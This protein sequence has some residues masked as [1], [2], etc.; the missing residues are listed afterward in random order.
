MGTSAR[1]TER[2]GE[3]GGLHPQVRVPGRLHLGTFH[4]VLGAQCLLA[5][6]HPPSFPPPP[7]LPAPP[8][9]GSLSVHPSA[10][11]PSALLICQL[12]LS[13]SVCPSPV[14][15]PLLVSQSVPVTLGPP[16]RRH[17]H[18]EQRRHV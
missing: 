7:S 15:I 8:Q 11:Q 14:S 13:S 17:Q 16:P 18:P 4:S 5:P 12:V 6:L 10:S 9:K 2:R 3:A 1:G